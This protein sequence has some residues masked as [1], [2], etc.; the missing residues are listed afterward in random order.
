MEAS[1][2]LD[3]QVPKCSRGIFLRRGFSPSFWT[4]AQELPTFYLHAICSSSSCQ[5]SVKQG[6][7]FPVVYRAL[8]L[9]DVGAFLVINKATLVPTVCD[10]VCS[11]LCQDFEE[12]ESHKP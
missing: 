11:S 1:G 2:G 10:K 5:L 3:P 12:K 9:G 8:H 6:W 7:E 4:H